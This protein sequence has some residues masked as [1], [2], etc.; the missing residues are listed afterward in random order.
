MRH[1]IRVLSKEPIIRKNEREGLEIQE[2]AKNILQ[3]E[4]YQII[5]LIEN[6]RFLNLDLHRKLEDKSVV[7][8]RVKTVGEWARDM[9]SFFTFV[10]YLCKKDNFYYVFDTKYKTYKNDRYRNKFYATK[11]EVYQYNR[12]TS[13]TDVKI[14]IMIVL[15]KDSSLLY[16]IYDWKDF[17]YNTKLEIQPDD[18]T[19][20]G[21]TLKE[22]IDPKTFKKFKSRSLLDRL[23]FSQIEKVRDF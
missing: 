2:L 6:H 7:E 3:S 13:T 4:G 15:N 8:R 10:D 20:I 11:N 16:G 1:Y 17:K 18:P 9:P 19:T 14:L 5:P 23:A 12:L 22:E 21:I